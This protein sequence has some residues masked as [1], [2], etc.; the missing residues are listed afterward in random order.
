MSKA[1]PIAARIGPIKPAINLEVATVPSIRG[2]A[3]PACRHC[4]ATVKYG[5]GVGKLSNDRCWPIVSF[6]CDAKFGPL[7]GRGGFRQAFRLA[8]LWVHGL[9]SASVAR[10]G[11]PVGAFLKPLAALFNSVMV[12]AFHSARRFFRNQ[13]LASGFAARPP[14]FTRP[15]AG[16]AAGALELEEMYAQFFATRQYTSASSSDSR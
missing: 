8:D 5:E 12:L 13:T 1:I 7:S 2:A 15:K 9:D 11:F 16:L 3:K 14:R 4:M 10:F 6:H